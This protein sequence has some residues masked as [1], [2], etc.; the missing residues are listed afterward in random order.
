M[1]P[2]RCAQSSSC[3]ESLCKNVH[4]KYNGPEG[5]YNLPSNISVVAKPPLLSHDRW[6][7]NND[8]LYVR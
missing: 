8:V 2:H 6:F 7:R 5:I 1:T 4:L 3:S